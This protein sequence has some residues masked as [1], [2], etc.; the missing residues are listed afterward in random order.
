MALKHIQWFEPLRTIPK[1]QSTLRKTMS[2]KRPS[3]NKTPTKKHMGALNSWLRMESDLGRGARFS[4]DQTL[5][6]RIPW[7]NCNEIQRSQFICSGKRAR[8]LRNCVWNKALLNSISN[9]LNELTVKEIL[10]GKETHIKMIGRNLN[11]QCGSWSL[12]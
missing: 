5:Q 9:P 11:A 2:N 4:I 1:R 7:H 12:V 6:V 8:I 10:R 3:G